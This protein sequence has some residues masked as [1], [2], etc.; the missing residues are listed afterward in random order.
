MNR[1]LLLGTALAVASF[2][3]TAASRPDGGARALPVPEPNCV[4]AA[5]AGDPTAGAVSIAQAQAVPNGKPVRVV[6]YLLMHAQPC[7]P[8][9]RGMQCEACQ[10]P[11]PYF[12]D[13][14]R[15]G[16][17]GSATWVVP[18]VWGRCDLAAFAEN[19]RFVLVGEWAHDYEPG[20]SRVLRASEII[21]VP[22]PR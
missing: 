17:G 6:A 1:R 22:A 11:Y 13:A 21:A 20:A 9:P 8:C 5:D 7:P 15:G 14:P 10:P 19:Q 2:A 12:G 4:A 18:A 3:A 16:A